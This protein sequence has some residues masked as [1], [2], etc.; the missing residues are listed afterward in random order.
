MGRSGAG[1]TTLLRTISGLGEPD[2]GTVT[3]P[4]GRIPFVFQDPRLLPWRTVQQNV[5]LVLA[6]DER[7]RATAWLATTGLADAA[8]MYP[9]ALSGGMRQ[10]VAI[11]R[12]LACHAPLLLVDEP[13]SHLDISTAAELRQEL[14]D[15]L[16]V[17]NSAVVWVTHNPAEAAE[18]AQRTVVMSGPPTGSWECVIH[19]NSTRETA[20]MLTDRLT[21]PLAAPVR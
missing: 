16:R 1:K 9:L 19:A 15:H 2:S 12:A 10:R 18:V 7:H 17:T 20:A 8:N 6:P 13:F 5:E 3:R 21:P 11:A 14:R 4:P